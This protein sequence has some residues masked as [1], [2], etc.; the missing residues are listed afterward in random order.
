MLLV[1][2]SSATSLLAGNSPRNPPRRQLLNHALHAWTLSSGAAMAALLARELQ[3][4]QGGRS[5]P[6]S[7]WQDPLGA[8]L[9]SATGA[10]ARLE[11]QQLEREWQ[12]LREG[13]ASGRIDRATTSEA[14]AAVLRV[15]HAIGEA[16]QVIRS[17]RGDW[18]GAID[19]LITTACIAEL[20][21]ASTVLASS[22]VLSGEARASIGWQWGACGWRSCGAQADASQA[23][24]KLRANLG[25]AEPLEARF[26]LDVAKRAV[27]EVLQLGAA[28]GVLRAEQL[29]RGEYLRREELERLLAADEDDAEGDTHK[30]SA[31]ARGRPGGSP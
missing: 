13:Q 27:D 30:A 17:E 23:L 15:R 2:A 26:Y 5:G 1:L 9:R 7:E 11:R 21:R 19:A 3:V 10:P 6:G 28:E 14:F 8:Q 31:C 29:P 22:S 25:M 24:C 20:E 16:D 18:R 4:L 12:Q